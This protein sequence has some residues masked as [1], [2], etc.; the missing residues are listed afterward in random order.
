MTPRTRARLFVLLGFVVLA[1]PLAIHAEKAKPVLKIGMILPIT[2]PL[3]SYGQEV[4]NGVDLALA[5]LKK[6]DPELAARISIVLQDTKSKPDDAEKMGKDLIN[7]RQ[8]DLIMGSVTS[9]TAFGIVKSLAAL[10]KPLIIPASTHP[11]IT[12]V[13]DNVFRTCNTDAYQGTLLAEFATNNLKKKNAAILYEES[14]ESSKAIANEFEREFIAKGGK[15]VARETY[16]SGTTDFTN[17]LKRIQIRHP[18]VMLV[19]G[20]YQD[21]AQIITKAKAIAM[22]LPI[23]GSDGWESPNLYSLA[24]KEALKGNYFATHFAADD[25][26]KTTQAF[27][28]AY[29]QNYQKKPTM[30][31]AMGYD[32]V[33]VVADAF[34]RSGSVLPAALNKS[35]AETKDVPGLMG[36]MSVN[37]DHDGEKA[38]AIMETTPSGPKFKA[39]VAL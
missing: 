1:T 26:D 8:A 19:P 38:A 9:S 28:S 7:S 22:L 21:A 16:P 31:A 24:S 6:A 25:Q 5:D 35:I 14:S 2:G 30:L 3:G 13:S 20:Y 27:V 18:Q 15:I 23:L 4:R 36:L 12:K 10:G 37:K 29:Q 17:I 33:L 11:A 39:R 34:K 32:S